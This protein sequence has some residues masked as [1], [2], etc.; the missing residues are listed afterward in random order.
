MQWRIRNRIM[1]WRINNQLI[2]LLPPTLLKT[3]W[4]AVYIGKLLV[5]CNAKT[6]GKSYQCLL[7]DNAYIPFYLGCATHISENRT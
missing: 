1:Q 4:N 3:Q 7:L 5:F 2:D 6:E